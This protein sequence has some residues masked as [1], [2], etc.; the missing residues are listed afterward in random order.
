MGITGT[1]LLIFLE[2]TFIFVV[3]LLLYSQR[4][5]IGETPFA[6]VLGMFLV[7]GEF[8]CGA[9]LRFNGYDYVSF[10]I[11]PVVVFVPFISALLLVYISDGVLALQRLI[12]GQAFCKAN[13]PNGLCAMPG[14]AA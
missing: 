13:T 3:M 1:I 5:S 9:D 2:M 11:A 7:Y 10:Q 8:L 14:A 12:I 6:I 4:K